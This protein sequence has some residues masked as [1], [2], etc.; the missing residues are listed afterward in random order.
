[1]VWGWYKLILPQPLPGGLA[2]GYHFLRSYEFAQFFDASRIKTN[3]YSLVPA[4]HLVFSVLCHP[5]HV[6]G[7]CQNNETRDCMEY[8][9]SRVLYSPSNFMGVK[10]STCMVLCTCTPCCALR[11]TCHVLWRRMKRPQWVN[12]HPPAHHEGWMV[13]GQETDF[14]WVPVP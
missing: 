13:S 6:S 8:D 12:Q 14:C 5:C 1:M 2:Q 11:N 3:F 10:V 9:M 4:Q 7:V